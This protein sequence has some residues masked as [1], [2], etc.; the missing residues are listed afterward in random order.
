MGPAQLCKRNV[1]GQLVPER[2]L[3][4]GRRPELGLERG[5]NRTLTKTPPAPE[6][7]WKLLLS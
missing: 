4:F 3:V 1:F 6:H 7:C 5:R 2:L